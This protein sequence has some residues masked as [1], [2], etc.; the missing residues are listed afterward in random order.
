MTYYYF[1][2]NRSANNNIPTPSTQQQ[3][4]EDQLVFGSPC[5]TNTAVVRKEIHSLDEHLQSVDTSPAIL[6]IKSTTAQGNTLL[7][8]YSIGSDPTLVTNKE[9]TRCNKK[10]GRLSESINTRPS[11]HLQAWN[12]VSL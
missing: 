6:H 11:K 3:F 10:T 1:T 12:E 2:E 7:H 4:M 8:S 5:K 9:N